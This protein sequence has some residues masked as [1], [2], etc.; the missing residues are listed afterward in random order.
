MMI[1]SGSK[2]KE[3]LVS[4]VNKG[5]L[6]EEMAGFPQKS[7][8]IVSLQLSRAFYVNN[9]EI[10]FPIKEGMVSGI[11][12]DWFKNISGI[13]NDQKHFQNAIVPSLMVEDVKFISK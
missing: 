8:G 1:P 10:M 13:G 6:I 3:D 12:F 2:S 7:S 5:I 4:E 9:G 11:A